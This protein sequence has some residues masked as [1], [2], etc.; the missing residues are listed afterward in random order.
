MYYPLQD[1]LVAQ[2]YEVF[3]NSLP[4]ASRN[5]P[6]PPASLSDD[7]S[8]FGHLMRKIV[9]QG[10]DIIVV[11]HSYGG[12]VASESAK[13]LSKA[14]RLGRGQDGGIAKIIFLAAIV[15][16]EGQSVT[17]H[18]GKPPSAIVSTDEV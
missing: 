7:A 1:V 11:G 16:P 5:A 18:Q 12:M 17:G 14:E 9:D 4:S 8:F 3:V 13:G 15:L 6:Q 10:R 2:G